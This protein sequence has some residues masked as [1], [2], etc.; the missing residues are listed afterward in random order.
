MTECLPV[1]QN[2]MI[3]LLRTPICPS[4]LGTQH[5]NL[6]P[7]DA[8]SKQ[9]DLYGTYVTANFLIAVVTKKPGYPLCHL[10]LSIL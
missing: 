3:F 5:F 2:R 9:H 4:F 6:R 8:V 10:S 1:T 7:D